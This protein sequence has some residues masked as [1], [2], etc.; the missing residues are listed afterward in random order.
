MH[1]C[2]LGGEHSWAGAPAEGPCQTVNQRRTTAT[3]RL[4]PDPTTVGGNSSRPNKFG[5]VMAQYELAI[6]LCRY[7]SGAYSACTLCGLQLS[8]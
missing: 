1:I 6:N 2:D 8:Y 7:I 4:K 5:I 3:D